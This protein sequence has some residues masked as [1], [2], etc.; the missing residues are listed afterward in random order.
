MDKR[1]EAA[2]NELTKI[3]NMKEQ[4]KTLASHSCFVD[5][6]CVSS[7]V[8]M[9]MVQLFGALILLEG[10]LSFCAVHMVLRKRI[11]RVI[12]ALKGLEDHRCCPA[13]YFQYLHPYLEEDDKAALFRVT[14]DCKCEEDKDEKDVAGDDETYPA[15][16]AHG[17][18]A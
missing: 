4:K 11:L 12:R 14:R 3:L 6:S 1:L 13:C 5:G 8:R 17:I 10:I 15:V 18:H 7:Q 16:K 9:Y 2:R